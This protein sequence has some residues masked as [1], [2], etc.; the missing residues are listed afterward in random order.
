MRKIKLQLLCLLFLALTLAGCGHDNVVNDYA[1]A[2]TDSQ[3]L[4]FFGNKYEA[5]NVEVIEEILTAYMQENQT[6]LISYE[7]LKGNDYYQALAQREQAGR[8]DDV[9]MINHDMQLA[10]QANGSLA[11]LTDL[12]EAAPFSEAMLSQMREPD[13]R[14]YWVPTTVSAFGLYCNLDLLAEHKQPVP[15]NLAEWEAVCDYFVEQGIVP[16]VANNDISLKTLALAKGFYPLYQQGEQAA[17]F[18]RLNSGEAKLSEYLQPG[19]EL[20]QEFCAKGYIDTAKALETAKT[21][22]DLQEFVQGRSPFMLTGVWAAGRVKQMNPGFEFQVI[23]YPVLEDGCV[24]VINPD[25]RL[26]AAADSANLALA[27]DFIAYFLQEENIAR[28]ADNQASFSPLLDE[29]QPS[30]REVQP[31]VESYRRDTLV[32]GSDSGIEFPIWDITAD[33]AKALLAG[34]DLA[35]ALQRMDA[36]ATLTY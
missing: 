33:V 24:L 3:Y 31:I 34:E 16:I 35:T 30:L 20:V 2:Q 19:W 29:Y 6:V 32:V 18:A 9:F 36:Q 28:F 4:H 5:S 26:S 22:D 12:A 10:F 11:D 13:G 15:Q 8:L 7:S 25:V 17:A 14:I 23:A 27:Q 1:G 21:S